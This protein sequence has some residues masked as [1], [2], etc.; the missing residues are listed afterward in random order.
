M[1]VPAWQ[2]PPDRFSSLPDQVLLKIIGRQ[3]F[4]ALA[5]TSKRNKD[6]TSKIINPHLARI[7]EIQL[8]PPRSVPEAE[9]EYLF[10]DF[11]Y[12]RY[13]LCFDGS[14]PMHAIIDYDSITEKSIHTMS[15]EAEDIPRLI[16][17]FNR[18]Y[19]FDVALAP[20]LRFVPNRLKPYFKNNMTVITIKAIEKVVQHALQ[21]AIPAQGGGRRQR[22][23]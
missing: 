22:K 2:P 4:S 15:M 5:S 13:V 19:D 14:V 8:A 9:L 17:F 7:T 18:F 11:D 21:A 6:A 16:R 3:G 20:E 12:N 1:S 23:R 10:L